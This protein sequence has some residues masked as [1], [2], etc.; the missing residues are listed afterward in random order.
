M[1]QSKTEIAS[2]VFYFAIVSYFIVKS[3]VES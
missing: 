3:L 2:V 1:K